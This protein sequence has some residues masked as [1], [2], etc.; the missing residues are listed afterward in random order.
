MAFDTFDEGINLGG[1]RSKTEIRTL[2]CYMFDKVNIP[3]KK[4]TVVNALQQKALANYFESSSCFDDLYKNN[5]IELVDEENKLY[6]I[7]AAGKMISKQLEDTLALTIKEKACE[8]V[9]GL[10]EQERIEKENVVTITKTDNG[11]SV[12]CSISGGDMD[13][14]SFSIYVPDIN[15][16]RIVRKNFHKNPVSFYNVIVSMLTRNK[17]AVKDALSELNSIL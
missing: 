17:G 11:Y 13:L 1:M 14:L 10:L 6:F 15:Q 8:C 7:T 9:L 4:E 5:N 2:I 16:A 3:M 12:N